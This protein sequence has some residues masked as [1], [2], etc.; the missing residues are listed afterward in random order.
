MGSYSLI[1]DATMARS[2][3]YA[4]YQ[5]THPAE[6]LICLVEETTTSKEYSENYEYSVLDPRVDLEFE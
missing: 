6:I 5:T 4:A 3:L 1:V 2:D